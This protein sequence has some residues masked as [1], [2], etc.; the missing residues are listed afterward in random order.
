MERSLSCWNPFLTNL[1]CNR[2]KKN[3]IKDLCVVLVT[4]LCLTLQP[5]GLSYGLLSIELFRQEY[6][7]VF[8]YPT[9][10][11]LPKPGIKPRSPALQA[12]SLP[13]EP[14]GKPQR[15]LGCGGRG[16][17]LRALVAGLRF[18]IHGRMLSL[19]DIRELRQDIRPGGTAIPTTGFRVQSTIDGHK[20]R[21]RSIG[22]NLWKGSK[23]NS[24]QS[25]SFFIY[26]L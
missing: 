17:I 21:A 3:K 6:Q 13:S 7:S 19:E 15:P 22:Y 16:K 8:P 23:K 24:D 2:C 12:D 1:W 14:P 11:D 10:E 20:V 25:L 26:K 18:E 9:P 4:Q 5:H